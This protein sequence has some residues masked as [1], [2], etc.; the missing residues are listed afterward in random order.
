MHH[1]Y[2][3]IL[4]AAIWVVVIILAFV[5]QVMP[6][7]LILTLFNMALG[8]SSAAALIAVPIALLGTLLLAFS[9]AERR[10]RKWRPSPVRVDEARHQK[11]TRNKAAIR[12]GPRGAL[13]FRSRWF[14]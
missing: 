6:L 13:D 8:I 5:M 4:H 10:R 9:L 1:R 7:L 2:A 12:H 14:F 3:T 11:V